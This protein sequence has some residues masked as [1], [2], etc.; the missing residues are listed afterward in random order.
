MT[1]SAIPPS[2][3]SVIAHLHRHRHHRSHRLDT[4]D[5]RLTQP[6]DKREH[7]I[8]FT[9]KMLDL[10]LCNRHAREV[11]NPADGFG[12]NRHSNNISLYQE[13][14]GTS[15]IAEG[16]YAANCRLAASSGP[17]LPTLCRQQTPPNLR[18]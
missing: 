15:A 2:V 17:Y 14:R 3:T 9:A 18:L 4:S 8:E 12:V 6:L 10:I 7:G 13:V 1:S 5:V 11:R 16:R